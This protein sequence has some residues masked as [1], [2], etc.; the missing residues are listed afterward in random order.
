MKKYDLIWLIS[1]LGV[2]EIDFWW[3]YINFW[4]TLRFSEKTSPFLKKLRNPAK[5]V[6][7]AWLFFFYQTI[8]QKIRKKITQVVGDRILDSWVFL[9]IVCSFF[10][11]VILSPISQ[12]IYTSQNP[13]NQML[14]CPSSLF[15]HCYFIY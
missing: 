7:R 9:E 13:I 4:K 10:R 5:L 11:K 6:L 14:Q 2:P 3:I 15:A 8:Y 12:P 1:G